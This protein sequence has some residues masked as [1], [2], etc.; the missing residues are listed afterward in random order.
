MSNITSIPTVTLTINQ[1]AATFE[2]WNTRYREDPESFYTEGFMLL[3]QNAA[4]YGEEAAN[5]FYQ[6][7]Q[8]LETKG[9]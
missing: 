5:Y 7:V 2:E 6:L 1:L 3:F 8:E 9:N 4:T